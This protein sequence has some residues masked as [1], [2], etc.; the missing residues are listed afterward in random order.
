MNYLPKELFIF[1][2]LELIAVAWIDFK[3][4][5]ISNIWV[6][7]NFIIFLL[8]YFILGLN[9]SF[10]LYQLYYPTI[11]F[12]VGF[13]FYTL[14][15]MGGG[16]SKFLVS[17]Y[18]ILPVFFHESFLISLLYVTTFVGLVQFIINSISGRDLIYKFLKYKNPKYLRLCYGKKFP[19]AP[20]ILLSWIIFGMNNF[21]FIK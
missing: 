6:L 13:A 14:R 4:R 7:L 2:I 1:L 18:I 19:F 12:I 15:I 17:I 11:F 20:I 21:E 16:D 8:I 10:E 9:L 5:K 3:Y